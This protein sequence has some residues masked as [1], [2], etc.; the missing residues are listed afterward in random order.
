MTTTTSRTQSPALLR[1]YGYDVEVAYDGNDALLLAATEAPNAVL[2]DI[3]LPSMDGIEVARRFARKAWET[4]PSRSVHG[5]RRYTGSAASRRAVR[6][7]SD[8][9]CP[10]SAIVEALNVGPRS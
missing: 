9:A 4:S 7:N 5:I 10:I 1:E 8:E 2:L 3:G 6:C